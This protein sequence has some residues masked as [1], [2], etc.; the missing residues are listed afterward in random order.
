[1]KFPAFIQFSSNLSLFTWRYASLYF[2][3]AIEMDDNELLTLEVIHRYVELLDKYFGSVSW[4]QFVEIRYENDKNFSFVQLGLW[5]GYHFQFWESIFYTG[6]VT[7]RWWNTGNIKE[8]CSQSDC[9]SRRAP[10]GNERWHLW[11][12]INA[13]AR[14]WKQSLLPLIIFTRIMQDELIEL[15]EP[16]FWLF[17]TLRIRDWKRI[18]FFCHFTTLPYSRAFYIFKL[19][20]WK[21][22][23]KFICDCADQNMQFGGRKNNYFSN[24][25]WK[26]PKKTLSLFAFISFI[27]WCRFFWSKQNSQKMEIENPKKLNHVLCVL[28]F[29]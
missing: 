14:E 28:G 18:H 21:S 27:F 25:T 13:K 5:I 16:Y 8:E 20:S 12:L 23:L 7:S 29:L 10:R 22:N 26:I 24:L 17:F 6:R 1:M 9:R 4:S 2:C 19:F 3:C 15:K 11:H